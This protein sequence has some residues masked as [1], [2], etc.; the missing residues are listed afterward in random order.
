MDR[1]E[2]WAGR[3]STN[4]KDIPPTHRILLEAGDAKYYL[5]CHRNKT[6]QKRNEQTTKLRK[7]KSTLTTNIHNTSAKRTP[8]NLDSTSCKVGLIVL[9]KK[10]FFGV[11]SHNHRSILLHDGK[12]RRAYPDEF[13]RRN[14]RN[15]QGVLTVSN[16]KRMTKVMVNMKTTFHYKR[17]LN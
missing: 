6:F 2:G 11:T 3:E 14:M 15:V 17:E 10:A 8:K 5:T 13:T 7:F 4:L 9:F 1:G 16:T 12:T